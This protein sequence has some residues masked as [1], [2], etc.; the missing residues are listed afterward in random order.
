MHRGA[1]AKAYESKQSSS[2]LHCCALLLVTSVL[3]GIV[4]MASTG[5]A[6]E[7]ATGAAFSLFV[8]LTF[9]TNE[10]KETFYNDFTPL[11]QW[12]KD[13]EPGTLA[14]EAINS[15][16]DPL[17]VL[18]VERYAD[19]ERD[20]LGAHRSS[21]PF[22]EFRPKLKALQDEGLVEVDGDSYI[23]SGAGFVRG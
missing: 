10:A 2:V 8:K 13:N 5:A 15:D 1:A 17:V 3:L 4:L 9:K 14:Y 11:A 21:K 22:L 12:I 6:A 19:K 16:K 23:D 20:F 18:I 7:S